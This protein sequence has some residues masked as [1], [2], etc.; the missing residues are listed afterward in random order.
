MGVGRKRKV[1]EKDGERKEN[2]EWRKEAK[3]GGKGKG[4]EGA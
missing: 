2:A 1:T 3:E 4:Q